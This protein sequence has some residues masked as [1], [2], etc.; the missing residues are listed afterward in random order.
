MRPALFAL[1]IAM[2]PMF[3]RLTDW[4]ARSLGV[5]RK[6]A[7]VVLLIAIAICTSPAS[8][9]LSTCLEVR[10]TGQNLRCETQEGGRG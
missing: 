8:F 5:G 6:V 2:A 7:F 10:T 3:D 4:I 1:A 9:Q